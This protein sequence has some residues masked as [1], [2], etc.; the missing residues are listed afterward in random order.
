L[1]TIEE[2]ARTLG[3]TLAALRGAEAQAWLKP[4]WPGGDAT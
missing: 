3:V 1:C 4:L 2:A